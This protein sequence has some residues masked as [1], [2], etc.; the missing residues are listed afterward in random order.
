MGVR[1]QR[2]GRLHCSGV[3]YNQPAVGAAAA[4]TA[5]VGGVMYMHEVAH[6]VTVLAIG[7]ALVLATMFMWWRDIIREAEYQ[8]HHTPIVQIGMR[9]I[10][11]ARQGEVDDARA[12]GCDIVTAYELHEI[13]MAAVLDR[14]P[15]GGPY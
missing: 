10:G 5:A 2:Q 1:L 7:M 3:S 4:F 6:G 9:G 15:D 14:I 8:G 11:S 13:G 12:Y